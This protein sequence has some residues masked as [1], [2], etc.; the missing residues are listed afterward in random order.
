MH[1]NA[2]ALPVGVSP[3]AVW[4]AA[5]TVC[6]STQ[7]E[8]HD[9]ET[10]GDSTAD[11]ASIEHSRAIDRLVVTPAPDQAALLMKIEFM[12]SAYAGYAIEAMMLGALVADGRRLLVEG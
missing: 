1:T 10:R 4:D 8:L 12:A 5:L 2:L 11:D 9:A 3:H 6:R 7:A